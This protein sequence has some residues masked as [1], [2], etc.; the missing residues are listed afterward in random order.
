MKKLTITNSD[1]EVL[2]FP[3]SDSMYIKNLDGFNGY[4]VAPTLELIPFRQGARTTDLIMDVR[5]MSFEV[6]IFA[7]GRE[8]DAYKESGEIQRKLNPYK[9]ECQIVVD[10]GYRVRKI[11]AYAIGVDVDDETNLE[12]YHVVTVTMQADDPFFVDLIDEVYLLGA[13]EPKFQFPLN[14]G[15]EFPILFRSDEKYIEVNNTGD[16]TTPLRMSIKGAFTHPR[17]TKQVLDEEGNVIKTE[18]M[19]FDTLVSGTTETMYIDTTPTQEKV[20]VVNSIG[21]VEDLIYTMNPDPQYQ[22]FQIDTGRNIITVT[23]GIASAYEDPEDIVVSYT[24]RYISA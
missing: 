1:G 16:V 23:Q 4:V 21:Q 5:I 15:I 8:E 10:T 22:Y 11:T 7:E 13:T 19:Q 2:A 3:I 14:E 17:I 18:Q 24:N 20:Y 9:G 12:G 6:H